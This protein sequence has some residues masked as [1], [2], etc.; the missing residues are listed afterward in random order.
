MA[1]TRVPTLIGSSPSERSAGAA[2]IRRS[3]AAVAAACAATSAQ[4]GRPL[5]V[6]DAGTN[7][8]GEGHL[9]V[10]AARAGRATTWNV[11]PAYA[12]ADGLALSALLARQTTDNINGSAVQLKWLITPGQDSGCN[13]GVSFGGTRATGQ[14]TSANAGFIIGL[15]SCHGTPA[16]SVHANLGSVKTSGVSAQGTWGIAL[17]R[18]FGAVTPH[19]EWFGA[20]GSKPT[21]SSARAATSPSGYS[22]T[23][24]SAAP[25]ALR[26]TAWA[27]SSG[28]DAGRASQ[29]HHR[30]ITDQAQ[31]LAP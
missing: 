17:E 5:T 8:F 23:A 31:S 6:D 7:A 24:R 10:F 14:G 4:A 26:S 3:L 2:H 30:P 13:L 11:S 12:F 15:F 27:S 16:G 25:P 18:Q 28:S 19:A 9:E 1:S 21:C 22:S 20:G 29:S